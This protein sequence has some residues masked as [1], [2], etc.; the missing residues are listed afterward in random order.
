MGRT[1]YD[2]LLA[3]FSSNQIF[4]D[5]DTIDPGVD[6]V[7]AIEEVVGACDV[8]IAVIGGRWLNV[9]DRERSAAAGHSRRHRAFRNRNRT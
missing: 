6:F 1:F 5:V 9:S 2:R 4:M 8:L 3:H 7:E